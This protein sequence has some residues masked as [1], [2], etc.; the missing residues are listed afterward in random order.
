MKTWKTVEWRSKPDKV[1]LIRLICP[2]CAT[3][4][5]LEIGEML[6]GSIIAAIG[7][8]LVFDPPN[9]DPPEDSM[10]QRIRCRSCRTLFVSDPDS[11]HVR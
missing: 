7:L 8:D 3:E 1:K 2:S 11:A 10:P 5:E 4:A 6:G 9:Y